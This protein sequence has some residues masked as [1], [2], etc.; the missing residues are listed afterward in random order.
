MAKIIGWHWGPDRKKEIK[1]EQAPQEPPHIE[2]ITWGDLTWVNIQ[3]PTE[4]ETEWL[5]KN[6]QFHQLALDDCLSRKQISK[7][8]VYAGYL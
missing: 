7:I 3:S 2:T 8:D 4:R 6:Y 1:Q 5:A